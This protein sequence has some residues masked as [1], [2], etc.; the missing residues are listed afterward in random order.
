LKEK[1]EEIRKKGKRV[2]ISLERSTSL[3]QEKGKKKAE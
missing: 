2:S 1:K 3:K